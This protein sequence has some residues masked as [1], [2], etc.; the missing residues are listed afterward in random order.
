MFGRP[1]NLLMQ[2]ALYRALPHREGGGVPRDIATDNYDRDAVRAQLRKELKCIRNADM[3]AHLAAHVIRQHSRKAPCYFHTRMHHHQGQREAA[4]HT[5]RRPDGR[6]AALPAPSEK[7]P[8]NEAITDT[9][10]YGSYPVT[11][12]PAFENTPLDL[13]PLEDTASIQLALIDALQALAANQIEPKRAGLLLYGLQV[14]SAN[15]QKM[16]IPVGGVRSVTFTENG[17][18]LAPQDYGYDVEDDEEENED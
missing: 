2:H 14:A 5:H 15:V 6:F 16:H 3:F 11:Q 10:D 9:I 12:P 17:T 18:P 7:N 13:A 8:N 1:Y 4:R